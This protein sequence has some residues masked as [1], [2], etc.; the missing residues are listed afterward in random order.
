MLSALDHGAQLP[1]EFV[2]LANGAVIPALRF[3]LPSFGV[4]LTIAVEPTRKVFLPLVP[5]R[6]A[7]SERQSQ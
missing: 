5:G 7:V 6:R 3:L 4:M 1:R 2:S